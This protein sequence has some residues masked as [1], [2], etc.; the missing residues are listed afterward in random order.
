MQLCVSWLAIAQDPITGNEQK[1]R[2]FW[3]RIL[4]NF[5]ESFPVTERTIESLM[6]RWNSHIQK[7]VNK[8]CGVYAQI[9]ARNQSGANC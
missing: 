8:F 1:S 7:N 2:D 5:A 4:S 6:V 3:A 9:E